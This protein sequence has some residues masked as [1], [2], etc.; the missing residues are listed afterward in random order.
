MLSFFAGLAGNTRITATQLIP[1]L[2]SDWPPYYSSADLTPA[3]GVRF[4]KTLEINNS[5]SL[6]NVK[7]SKLMEKFSGL[8]YIDFSCLDALVL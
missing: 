7:R 3:L 4:D 1:L 8:S 2:G 5:L 6:F